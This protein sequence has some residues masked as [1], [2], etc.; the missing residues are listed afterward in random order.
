MTPTSPD[1]RQFIV[2]FER[3]LAE[4]IVAARE[5]ATAA[6]LP[7]ANGK[8]GEEAANAGRFAYGFELTRADDSLVPGMECA[9]RAAGRDY[10]VLLGRTS[11]R[12]LRLWARERLPL[13]TPASLIMTPWRFFEKLKTRLGQIDLASDGV[14]RALALFGKGERRPCTPPAPAAAGDLNES[15]TRAVQLCAASDI[16]FV[17]GPP[18]T[19]KTRTLARIIADLYARGQRL[20]VT[21]TTNAAVDE[22]LAKIASSGLLADALRGTEV[23]R[24]GQTEAETH[25]AALVD[26]LLRSETVLDQRIGKL[27]ARLRSSAAELER[28]QA[29]LDALHSARTSSQQS[30]FGETRG[31]RLDARSSY[32]LATRK[33]LR[34]LNDHELERWLARRVER[35][36]RVQSLARV[37]L[38]AAEQ[39]LSER[40]RRVVAGARVVLATLANVYSS[41]LLE[42]ERFDAVIV[43]EAGMAS[44]PAVF[45]AATLSRRKLIMVGDPEQ[46][47]PIV[48]A[49]TP[50]SRKV[51][52]RNIFDVSVP[53]R[54]ESE[55]VVMLDEQ[56]RMHP[57]IGELV[58]QLFYDGKLRNAPGVAEREALALL[59]PFP[60]HA[61]TVVDTA[62]HTSCELAKG[63][64]S[65]LNAASA[66][67]SVE[68][69]RR[70]RAA[71]AG[72]VAIVTPYAQQ[73]QH[74]RR[75]LGADGKD[76]A[77]STV[78]RF[79]G[80]ERDVI[81]LDTV[82]A[83][84][85]KPGILTSSTDE[86]GSA[87]NLINVSISRARGKLIVI[88][89][90]EYF[91]Q[92]APGAP[93]TRL[94]E[95][96]LRVGHRASPA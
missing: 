66:R 7:L 16:A 14:Q 53:N 61:V 93:V 60:G 15:Q 92:Q 35:L 22:A 21:S 87:A 78:H 81:V 38:H 10:P 47:P 96:A 20:L 8:A 65:R 28:T 49:R 39:R 74:I 1:A 4:E 83:P 82:D 59:E 13:S 46:L 2:A 45:F 88:A 36:T 71:G 9:V 54:H 6:E 43:E 64:H 84:P 37:G 17:W 44:L 62:G 58:S 63:S 26:V 72:D 40:E 3:A 68:L 55:L 48:Q 25:G 42:G 18:G 34:A 23:V 11:G 73:A 85:Q 56:H 29:A 30:L 52:G 77:C 33:R 86:Q 80:Q 91:K 79:Q 94:I 51:M 12:E 57:Q 75:M 76:I 90:V 19:G 32:W 41:P 5:R 50:L 27:R 24:L 89:D 95:A 31:V 67:L 69:A 70:A